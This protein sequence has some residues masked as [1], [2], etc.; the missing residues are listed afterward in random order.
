MKTK[1]TDLFKVD[2][3]FLTTFYCLEEDVTGQLDNLLVDEGTVILGKGC[4]DF[5]YD[6]CECLEHIIP[7]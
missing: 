7:D 4:F 3:V 6:T 2:V 5:D 1:L